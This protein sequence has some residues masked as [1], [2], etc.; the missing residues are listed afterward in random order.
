ME[1]RECLVAAFESLKANKLRSSLT[2]LGVIIG[3]AL[4]I[5][6]VSMG[7][8]AKRY[9][10]EEV[11][12]MGFGS[13]ALVLHPGKLDP[14]IEPSKL[15]YGDSLEIARRV[16][17]I[18]GLVPILIGSGYARYGKNEHKTA[19]WG[20]TENYD[21]LV[22]SHIG[23]GQFMTSLDV[24]KHRKVCVLGPTLKEKL[25]GSFS[26]VGERVRLLGR[27]FTI[28]GVM[29]PKGEMLGFNLDDMAIMPV[30]TAQDLMDSNKLNEIVIWADSLEHLPAVRAGIATLLTERHFD[31][32]DFHF[33]TQTEMLSILGQ[34][35]GTLTLFVSGV[36]AISLV[37]G[38]IG[39]MNIML[40][41]V[42]ERTREIGI[43]KAIGARNRDIF[44][45][46]FAEAMV[47][48]LTG[49]LIGIVSGAGLGALAMHLIGTPIMLSQWA[50][51]AAVISSVI[52]G[53]AAGVY[54]AMQAAQ[55]DPIQALRYE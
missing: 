5:I 50:V 54:P 3:V 55:Q 30:T 29:E 10:S 53:L 4:V 38:S 52:V 34:I 12:G 21:K 13:N 48:S 14:P 11:G 27:K 7:E 23:E 19:F 39:I 42:M 31:R 51:W 44:L 28:I 32:D 22:N 1:F 45:Q 24:D 25:F 49:G 46:F 9:V 26:P 6:L 36:A 35:T 47:V 41:S 2:M 40:V 37:V 17:H 43:R 18:Q 33:H 15:T 8:A 20:L 16:P